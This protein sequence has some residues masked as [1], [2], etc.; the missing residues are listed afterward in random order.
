MR[1]P[2]LYLASYYLVYLEFT[3]TVTFTFALL[4]SAA[5][6]RWRRVRHERSSARGRAAL[7]RAIAGGDVR[8]EDVTVVAR[9]PWTVQQEL[10]HE[11]GEALTGSGRERLRLLGLRAGVARRAERWCGSAWWWRRLAGAR[12]LTAL[13]HDCPAVRSLLGDRNGVVRAQ[14]FVWAAGRADEPIIDELVSRLADPERLCRFTVQD[15]LLRLGR[16]AAR[17]LGR[18]LSDHAQP[19]LADALSV[20]RGLA[21]PELLAPALSLAAH[22]DREVRARACAVLGVL[23]GDAA[24]GTLVRQ[25]HDA[26]APVRAAAARALGQLGA[27]PSASALLPLLGDANWPV[28][29]ESAL[30]LRRMGGA[31]LLT[32]RRALRSDNPFVADM[33]RQVLDLPEAVAHRVTA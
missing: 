18:F 25:L 7:A 13:A 24:V 32:L 20:A 3:L 19:G 22:P 26:E 5:L 27:W 2:L 23:G 28:R 30:A 29:R 15:S 14:A 31:G 17:A 9:L 11:F 10:V 8:D 12:V 6:S 21:Q 1:E 4:L 33:A 16:P